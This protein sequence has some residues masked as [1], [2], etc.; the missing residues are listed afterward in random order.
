MHKGNPPVLD[1]GRLHDSVGLQHRDGPSPAVLLQ[2]TVDPLET[3][4][5]D[6]EVPGLTR[7]HVPKAVVEVRE[8]RKVKGVS[9]AQTKN[10]KEGLKRMYEAWLR[11]NT[12]VR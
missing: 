7:T 1:Q 11:D 4:I 8:K 5:G 2:E 10:L 9:T 12:F 6:K 3:T